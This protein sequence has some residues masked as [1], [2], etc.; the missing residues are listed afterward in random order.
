MSIM[1]FVIGAIIF[2]ILTLVALVFTIISLASSKN[3]NAL[4]W[5]ISFVLV[6]TLTV[7]CI[8]GIGRRMRE[9]MT[10]SF[11]QIMQQ[12]TIKADNEY[13][14]ANKMQRQVF[15]D[16]LQNYINENYEGKVPVEFYIN[17]VADTAANG[18]LVV[19]FLYPYSMR[20][21]E[22]SY[23]GKISLESNDSVFV[24]NI[25]QMAFDRNFVI[26]RI[27]NQSDA[28]AME[29]GRA[30]VEYVFFDMRT[31]NFEVFPNKQMLDKIAGK[32][33]YTGPSDMQPV[34]ALY[35]AWIDSNQ[36]EF[37]DSY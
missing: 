7:F 25:S 17:R 18:D 9:K 29:K 27:D 6:L 24:E 30:E 14:Q 3:R 32:I 37:G 33:G 28:A 35:S 13:S 5:G 12:S 26:C 11:E 10:E 16:T 1:V 21:N 8:L 4:I 19:P 34:S 36:Y 23:L 15:L 31:G 22:D 2:G 20:I